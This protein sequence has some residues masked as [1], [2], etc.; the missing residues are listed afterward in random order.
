MITANMRSMVALG[1][2]RFTTRAKVMLLFFVLFTS[3]LCGQFSGGNG[4]I[5][6]PWLISS[7]AE[8]NNIRYYP[9]DSFCLISD[10]DLNVP[11]YN[12]GEGWYPIGLSD[13]LDTA[14]A[15]EFAGNFTGLFDGTQYVISGLRI[16]RLQGMY[17][18]LFGRLN[19]ASLN[20]III[21]DAQ[22]G[23]G[24]YT[25]I[26]AGTATNNTTVNDIH[27]QGAIQS[28]GTYIGL[29]L[30]T[31]EGLYSSIS[32]VHT[33]GS[34]TGN[35]SQVGGVL[36][37]LAWDATMEACKANVQIAVEGD[38]VGGLVGNNSFYTGIINSAAM[39]QVSGN[40]KVGGLVGKNHE[41]TMITKCF[42]KANVTGQSKVGGFV[43]SHEL[44]SIIADSYCRGNVLGNDMVGGFVGY[45]S[46][47]PMIQKCYSTGIV[48]GALHSGGFSGFYESEAI[49]WQ[50]YWDM[51]S[52]Q[53]T[54]SAGGTGRTTLQLTS[55]PD[56]ETYSLWDFE[57]VWQLDLLES[58]DGYPTLLETPV[59]ISDVHIPSAILKLSSYPNPFRE[60]LTLLFNTKQQ[61][62]IS[63]E[64]YNVKGQKVRSLTDMHYS[65]GDHMLIWD[66]CDNSGN[67]LGSGIYF[68]RMQLDGKVVATRKMIMVR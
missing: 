60:Q 66:G 32:D 63:C 45:N 6:S 49:I 28:F 64:F 56:T 61:G 2:K 34:I 52:S 51:Q 25:G 4:T 29:A 12:E 40:S 31:M 47:T 1:L 23:G 8:L 27:I 59:E 10:I 13:P 18:G 17:Q 50:C 22:I 15:S 46:P 14:A 11:P 42:S 43:G 62:H 54:Y 41:N 58:N 48:N 5:S 19:H 26:L 67:K 7:P 68:M 33:T 44:V 65:S 24:T 30:G 57:T 21:S 55:A 37:C 3:L 20:G 39:G 16:A 38:E 9:N 36:G 53:I 35:A